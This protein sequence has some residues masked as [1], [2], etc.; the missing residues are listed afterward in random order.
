MQLE[1]DGEWCQLITRPV[2]VCQAAAGMFA[3]CSVQS[4]LVIVFVDLLT[5]PSRFEES[6]VVPPGFLAAPLPCE[7][8]CLPSPPT[9][10]LLSA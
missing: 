7:G 6:P 8:D 4:N 5:T 1:D 9:V 10:L 2:P 3:V